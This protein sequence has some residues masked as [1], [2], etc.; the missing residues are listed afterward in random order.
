MVVI[1]DGA[2][3]NARNIGPFCGT[4]RPADFTSSG[5]KLYVKLTTDGSGNRKGF[6]ARFRANGPPPCESILTGESGEFKSP[7]FPG[8]YPSNAE[9]TWTITVPEHQKVSLQFQSLDIDCA[10]DFIEIHDGS[11]GS[12]RKIGH[13]CGTTDS[14]LQLNSTGNQM[15]VKLTTD[16]SNQQEGFEAKFNTIE[17]AAGK[18]ICLSIRIFGTFSTV[19]I[20]YLIRLHVH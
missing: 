6:E 4:D 10:G 14:T 12:A 9:C 3:A 15:Y 1:Y 19:L 2:D 16:G 8:N 17:T 7:N 18:S 20:N 13:F 11:D 5:N